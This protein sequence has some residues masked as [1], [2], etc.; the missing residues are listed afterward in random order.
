MAPVELHKKY[1]KDLGY[2]KLKA[3]VTCKRD[4]SIEHNFFVGFRCFFVIQLQ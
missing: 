2:T 4:L 1:V 3:R